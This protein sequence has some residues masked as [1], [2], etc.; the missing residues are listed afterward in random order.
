MDLKMTLDQAR[1]AYVDEIRLDGG[2][3]NPDVRRAFA[4][5]PREHFYGPGPWRFALRSMEAALNTAYLITDDADPCS[6]YRNAS[7]P[8]D[9]SRQLLSGHPGLVARYLD[10][11]AVQPGEHMLHLGSGTGY[12]TALLAELV[13]S[14]GRVV[15]TEAEA[16]LAALAQANL[17]ERPNVTVTHTTDAPGEDECADAILMSFGVTHIE[18][19]WLNKLRDGGRLLVSLTVPIGPNQGI[20][21]LFKVTR[22]GARFK[23][24]MLQPTA[25]FS[26]VGVRDAAMERVLAQAMQSGTMAQAAEVRRDAHAPTS[27]CLLHREGACLSRSL[28]SMQPSL[29]P[30]QALAMSLMKF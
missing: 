7:I 2:A 17:A 24:V 13:G 12:Y 9:E 26:G 6:I 30:P 10:H 27:T 28:M 16:R 20:G 29:Q 8:L 21:L 5:V 11:L 25:G 1:R 14:A 4:T 15:A 23:A 22:V 19:Q 3:K 18:P